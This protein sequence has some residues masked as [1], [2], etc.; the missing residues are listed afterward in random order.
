MH[1]LERF[2]LKSKHRAQCFLF[3]KFTNCYFKGHE[4][5]DQKRHENDTN[6]WLKSTWQRI[7]ATQNTKQTVQI[8]VSFRNNNVGQE[9][10]Q[11]KQKKKECPVD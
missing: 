7:N 2:L 10:P 11:T 4:K 5:A 8:G 3:Y 1:R 6:T 9:G